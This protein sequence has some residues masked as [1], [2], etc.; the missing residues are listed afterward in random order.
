MSD[1]RSLTLRQIDQPRI[2]FASIDFAYIESDLEFIMGQLS[3]IPTR[4][5]RR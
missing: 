4:K 2:D 5:D 1:E 3:R